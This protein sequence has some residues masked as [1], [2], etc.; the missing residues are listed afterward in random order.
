[1]DFLLLKQLVVH[2]TKLISDMRFS[3]QQKPH[4]VTFCKVVNII[5]RHSSYTYI[6]PCTGEIN[7]AG[8]I[9][10]FEKHIK[11]TI[12]LPFSIVSDKD[13]LFM[14]AEFRDWIMKNSITH[15]VSATDHHETD[16]QTESKNRQLTEMFAD[17]E[18]PGTDWLTAASKVQPQMNSR[19]SKS[20]AQSPFFTLSGF[21]P[22]VSSTELPHPIPVY[23]DRA[24]RH[25][26]AA[27]K[28]NSAKH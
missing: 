22:Q 15:K 21:Q 11:P 24:Q 12:G 19:V 28:L 10:I 14:S 2:C 3:D 4:F 27:E 1:M 9:H 8:V 25:S 13:V 23:S 7:A 6:I 16:G 18:L 17:H 26:S 20:R 5:D